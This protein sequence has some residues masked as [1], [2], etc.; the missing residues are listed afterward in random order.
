MVQ[1]VQTSVWY[2]NQTTLET[3]EAVGTSSRKIIEG[4]Q[5]IGWRG[6]STW[7]ATWNVYWEYK[8]DGQ[9]SSDYIESEDLEVASSSWPIEFVMRWNAVRLPVA[10]GY[11]CELTWWV[12]STQRTETIYVTVWSKVVYTGSRDSTWQETVK[13]KFNAGKF[14]ELKIGWEFYWAGS[15]SSSTRLSFNPAPTLKIQLQ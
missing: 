10:W 12:W 5:T 9:R 15:S 2:T 14:D 4:R 13:F 1:E 6:I 8:W 3:I 11:E 7:E